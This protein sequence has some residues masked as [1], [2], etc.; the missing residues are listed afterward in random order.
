MRNSTASSAA[1]ADVQAA[2]RPSVWPIVALVAGDAVSFL[3]FAAAGRQSHHEANALGQIVLT[4]VP[5][6]AGWFAV[7]PFVGAFRRALFAV[8]TRLLARTEL[9][10][11]CAWPVALGLRWAVSADHQ[12]PLSFAIVVL[13]SNA[14]FLGIWRSVFGLVMRGRR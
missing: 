7:A 12:I 10:W 3:V 14:L 8:P 9:A 6:A 1:P 4:A 5:F 2:S 13:V 11:L